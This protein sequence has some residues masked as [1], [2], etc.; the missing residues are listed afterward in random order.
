MLGDQE[1]K[2]ASVLDLQRQ[3]E[4]HFF[5]STPIVLLS[6]CIRY[7]LPTKILDTRGLRKEGCI[8]AHNLRTLA[9][10]ADKSMAALCIRPG[11]CHLLRKSTT[12][13]SDD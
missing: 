8:L 4:G 7:L 11:S 6:M 10:I 13:N 5:T 2:N 1:V 12:P 3:A 9:I